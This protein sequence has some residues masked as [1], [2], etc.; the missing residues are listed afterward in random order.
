MAPKKE[1][2]APYQHQNFPKW[3]YAPGGKAKLVD[4]VKDLEYWTGEGWAE[5]PADFEGDGDTG[6]A[7][8]GKDALIAAL[9]EENAQ[10]RQICEDAGIQLVE[11]DEPVIED[12]G[13]LVSEGATPN[14]N[15]FVPQTE[16]PAA[17]G[18]VATDPNDV[19]RAAATGAQVSNRKVSVPKQGKAG[20]KGKSK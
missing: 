12:A 17:D 20:T 19:P 14:A 13:P 1:E 2:A 18:T 8:S 16:E 9:R 10:L 4:N 3:L 11:G 7:D 15:T 6:E 5:S